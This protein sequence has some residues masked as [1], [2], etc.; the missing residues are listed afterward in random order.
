MKDSLSR[1]QRALTKLDKA[2]VLEFCARLQERAKRTETLL[3]SL[4]S[5]YLVYD[6]RGS[7]FF[8]NKVPSERYGILEKSEGKKIWKVVKN[9]ALAEKL[10]DLLDSNRDLDE[11]IQTRESKTD[12]QFYIRCRTMPYVQSKSIA[13]T[14]LQIYDYTQEQKHIEELMRLGRLN[15][16]SDISSGL[17]HEIKN[18]LGAMGIHIHL[19]KK[20]LA[21][22]SKELAKQS[23]KP[24]SS[25]KKIH[26][27]IRVLEEELHALDEVVSI[28]LEN[29]KKDSMDLELIDLNESVKMFVDFVQVELREKKIYCNLELSKTPVMALVSQSALRHVLLNLAKNSMDAMEE[30]GSLFIKTGH[31]ENIVYISFSDTGKGVDDSIQEKIFNPYFT[32]KYSGSGIGLSIVERV[33]QVHRGKIRIDAGYKKGA[34]FILEFPAYAQ[35]W[36]EKKE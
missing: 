25:E 13:G 31:L 22:Q 33:M 19:L 9:E 32:T 27:Y 6:L 21:K 29:M 11:I 7:V 14:I 24:Q 5:F 16:L 18:P 2:Q 4:P 26:K 35:H 10:R 30:K 15:S 8:Q 36:L 1:S 34:R 17:A 12:E 20:E 23:K 28:F 3:G